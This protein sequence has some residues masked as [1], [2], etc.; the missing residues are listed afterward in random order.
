[1]ERLQ[2][3]TPV[4]VLGP[5]QLVAEVACVRDALSFLKQWPADRRGP[6]YQCAFNSCLAAVGT[7]L[8]AEDA[9]KSFFSF[10]H[11]TGILANEMPHETTLGTRAA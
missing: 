2:F 1:M 4:R 3:F 7:Q 5:D 11:I 9:R 6:V 10:A 8:S